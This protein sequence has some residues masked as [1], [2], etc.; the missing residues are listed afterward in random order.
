M[1]L[2]RLEC[3]YDLAPWRG[4][5]DVVEEFV[6]RAE[7][8]KQARRLATSRGGKELEVEPAAWLSRRFSTCEEIA[9]EGTPTLIAREIRTG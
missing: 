4:N 6:I 9:I 1:K 8:E 3:H 5:W 7:T 2:W